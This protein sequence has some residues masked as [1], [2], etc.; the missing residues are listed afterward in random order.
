MWQIK[1]F[2]TFEAYSKW[3][4]S[5]RHTHQIEPLFVNNAWGVEYRPLKKIY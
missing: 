5:H 4:D 2:K 3:I 1:T